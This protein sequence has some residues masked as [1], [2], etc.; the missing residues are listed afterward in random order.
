[1]SLPPVALQRANDRG[2]GRDQGGGSRVVLGPAVSFRRWRRGP[3]NAHGA[4]TAEFAVALPA[5]L[6]LL[7]LLLAGASA[8]VTQLRLEEAARAGARALARGE[9]P[10]AVQGIVTTLAGTSATASVAAEGEWLSVTVADG[11]GG[12]LGATVPWTLTA[13]ATTRSERPA[14]AATPRLEPVVAPE[15]AA[16]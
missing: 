14:A 6:L 3:G 11:V 4:V 7:A 2:S 1:M 16:A 5:V 10:A 13:R 8:G 12:P 9:D 15:E